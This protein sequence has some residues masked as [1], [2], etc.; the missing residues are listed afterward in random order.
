MK[1]RLNKTV[2]VIDKLKEKWYNL[3]VHW[4]IVPLFL[5]IYESK[6]CFLREGIEFFRF[7][8][9]NIERKTIK[10]QNAA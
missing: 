10:R 9:Y 3:S 4:R 7:L 2:K 8:R 6:K 5:G 1:E